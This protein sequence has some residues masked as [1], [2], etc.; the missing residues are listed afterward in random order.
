MTSHEANRAALIRERE[1]RA[2]AY[3]SALAKRDALAPG[4]PDWRRAEA[5][6]GLARHA[7]DQW[8]DPIPKAASPAAQPSPA[9]S[10]TAPGVR[11]A[12][13]ARPGVV[14]DPVEAVAARIL[15]SDRAPE[16]REPKSEIDAVA[17]RIAATPIEGEA[18]K[19]IKKGDGPDDAEDILRKSKDADDV[20]R[21]ILDS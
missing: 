18:K 10:S 17:M 6:L 14:E 8:G 9:P 1:A 3:K 5:R 11:V 19:R 20:A 16:P 21:R 12:P 15:A 2:S 13:L 4:T 7:L